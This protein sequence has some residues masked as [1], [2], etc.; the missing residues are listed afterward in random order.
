M[1]IYFSDFFGCEP[2]DLEK[3]GALDISLLADLPLFVDPFLL[4][5]SKNP[6]YQA[7]HLQMIE[8]IEFLQSKA[9][10]G[11]VSPDLLNVWYK[12]AEVKQNWLGYSVF[13]NGG[14]GLGL[15]FARSLHNNL[16]TIFKNFGKENV[17]TGAHIEK[18]C[19]IR[20]GVGR[21][22]ISDFTT[23]LI[24]NF[25]LEYTQRFAEESL[26][27]G[28]TGAFNIQK[29][30]F[31][32]NTETWEARQFILPKFGDDFVILTP[33]DIL[34]RDDTWI[35][36]RDLFRRY[37]HLASSLPNKHLRAQI[38]NYF[39]SILPKRRG[40]KKE[41]GP[42]AE[43]RHKAINA[44]LEKFPEIL[45][46]YV[47]DREDHGVEATSTSVAKVDE[48]K[49]LFIEQ[50]KRLVELLGASEFYK[51]GYDT[52]DAALKRVMFL[53]QV[54]E[55]NDGYRFFYFKGQA[56][57]REE[58][59]KLI[60]RLTWYATPFEVDTEV[61]NGRGPVDYKISYGSTDKSLV[62]FKLAS[63]KKLRDNLQHQVEVY[64]KAN[65]TKK[66]LK[67]IIYFTSEE[68]AR[69]LQVLKDLGLKEDKTI[70]LIDARRDNKP[71]ASTVMMRRGRAARKR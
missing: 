60:Y 3:Y 1:Q 56:I 34:T 37:D 15:R 69:V 14:R 9:E 5:N 62:E 29:V 20:S 41:K 6:Q 67:V 55:N 27:P 45:D 43:E 53:K 66:S 36:Q 18:V 12:F 21:D 39:R 30:A 38:N 28:V 46:Y 2:E 65:Q 58:D 52:F 50:V 61:N 57:E 24:K 19:L 11:M 26:D 40:K 59:L 23:N 48:T 17:E 33:E 8:Y 35:S 32:Y 44:V 10:S 71:S 7:L 64:K 13:G 63:N 16:S 31:N 47:K 25:L 68:E 54:I 51:V 4:F 22:N 49:C 42:T 70:I